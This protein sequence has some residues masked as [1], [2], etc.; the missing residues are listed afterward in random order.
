MIRILHDQSEFSERFVAALLVRILRLEEDIRAQ[1]FYDRDKKL[2]RILLKLAHLSQHTGSEDVTLPRW[3]HETL[4]KMVG[5]S[6]SRITRVMNKFRKTGLIDYDGGFLT[7]RTK[8]LS[9]AL[10]R[11]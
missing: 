4:A 3:T 7:V 8:R 6:R 5:T 1:F 9:N 10:S 2:A 11:D